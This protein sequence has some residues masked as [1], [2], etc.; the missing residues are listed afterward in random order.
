MLF[1]VI[2]ST[3]KRPVE[4]ALILKALYEQSLLLKLKIEVIISD[5]HSSEEVVEVVKDAISQYSDV[6]VIKHVH[7][8]NVLATK[9]NYGFTFAEAE[10]IIFLDDD[11]VPAANFLA[12]CL[13]RVDELKE[14]KVFCGEIRFLSEQISE[15]NYYRFRD[16][17]HPRDISGDKKLNEWTFVAMNFLISRENI[18][19]YNLKFNESF[20]GYGAE[21]H[22]YGFLLV[23]NGFE[24]I[25]SNQCIMH[26]EY[27]G[28]IEKYAKKI[29]H[30]SRDG[31]L[32]MKN[33]HGKDY[34][35]NSGKLEKI[36][37]FFSN[38][39]FLS[40]AV[41]VVLFNSFM[42][43]VVLKYLKKVD[44]IG[45]LY[46]NTLFRYI[47]LGAYINGLKDRKNF[48]QNVDLR[49]NWYQ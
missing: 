25:Q 42:M 5:S 44:S 27:G 18:I 17:R 32:T 34:V 26:Y 28:D 30:S 3:W 47:I 31:M 43:N 9:R 4:L 7:T 37:T 16:S 33:T 46:S 13:N 23:D 11:C 39:G 20:V 29:Y 8:E 40:T 2:I 24:I 22:D 14:K 38:Q 1:S 49:N 41:V 36:E 19:T 12:N 10:N 35:R 15:S 21:D 45:F 48:E 6:L